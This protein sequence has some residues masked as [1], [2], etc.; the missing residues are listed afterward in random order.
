MKTLYW[1]LSYH[2]GLNDYYELGYDH[3]LKVY[4]SLVETDPECDTTLGY[5]QALDD[6]KVIMME[7]EN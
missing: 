7:M 6:V 3:M 1:R 4:N 5:K 2:N